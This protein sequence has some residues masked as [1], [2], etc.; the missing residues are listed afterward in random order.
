MRL[1]KLSQRRGT[2]ATALVT[3]NRVPTLGRK[4]TI[5]DTEYEYGLD[6]AVARDAAAV[7]FNFTAAVN[8]DP[9][10]T[11]KHNQVTPVRDTHAVRYGNQVRI[12][13]TVPGVAG[14]DIGLSQ[15]EAEVPGT[16]PEVFVS[17][18]HLGGGV[19]L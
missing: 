5:G 11:T 10:E 2:P 13:A 17:H 9:N 15:D 7:A 16:Q 19:D 18:N 3:F 4:I 8:S 6:F 14:N 1:T 12:I